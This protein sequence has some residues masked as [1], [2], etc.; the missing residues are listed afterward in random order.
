[1]FALRHRCHRGA[2]EA[3][4]QAQLPRS[5]RR[6]SGVSR[7]RLDGDNDSRGNDHGAFGPVNYCPDVFFHKIH[8]R[9]PPTILIFGHALII[10]TSETSGSAANIYLSLTGQRNFFH[11][12]RRVTIP[13]IKR[14]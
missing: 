10:P 4:M 2:I 12:C 9:L 6:C 3:A 7:S 14:K 11:I 13:C 1:M 8:G 5:P